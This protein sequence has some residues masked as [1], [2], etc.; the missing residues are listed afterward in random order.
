MR[1]RRTLV[2]GSRS[3]FGIYL[4]TV[5]LVKDVKNM[6][7]FS[8]N[9]SSKTMTTARALS[10]L[11]RSLFHEFVSV[12]F[13]VVVFVGRWKRRTATGDDLESV[14]ASDFNHGPD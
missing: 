11:S 9:F 10:G 12:L 8:N 4:G 6:G 13:A 7:H 3:L 1:G 2:F 5:A 14:C